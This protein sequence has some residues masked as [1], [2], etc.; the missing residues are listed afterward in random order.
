MSNILLSSDG[1]IKEV[2]RLWDVPSGAH[3]RLINISEN[4]TYLVEAPGGYKSILRVHRE[5][6]HTPNAIA[7][8]LAWSTALNESGGVITPA[9]LLGKNNQ[10]IQV[11]RPKGQSNDRYMV[12]FEFIEGHEPDEN[13]D[14][15]APFEELGEITA[16]THNHSVSWKRPENFE[17]MIWNLDAVFGSDPIWGRWQD[18]PN[19]T[20]EI[21]T[22]LE[23]LEKVVCKR[24]LAFGQSSDR[25]G[26]IH[27]DLRLAN[28][29]VHKGTT[30]LIDFDDCGL[31]WF[32]YDFA[33]GITFMEDSS[34]VPALKKA[35]MKG[36]RKEREISEE[37]EAEIDTFVM[38]RRMAL[39]AW[40]GSHK[41]VDIA[42]QLA[43]D[44][45]RITAELGETYLQKYDK[46]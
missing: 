45:A 13:Q 15:V 43:P 39:L 6:Y 21:R 34:Q 37:E 4:E 44:F 18:G 9:F 12:M 27:A 19:V 33:T 1:L 36:Y 11:I 41:E 28:L 5:N 2:L 17:R 14:L 42:E 23:R 29:L 46:R 24:L 40:I 8:E 16:K 10:P 31:G 22:K 30:R 20:A 3:A 35:W 38:L 25:Y 32:L 26:L 7:C